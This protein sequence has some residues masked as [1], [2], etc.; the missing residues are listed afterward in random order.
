ML[1]LFENLSWKTKVFTKFSK[2]GNP[3]EYRNQATGG[4]AVEGPYLLGLFEN[5]AW[6]R[7]FTKFLIAGEPARIS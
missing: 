1:D 7:I 5:I 6:N 3:E 4:T 2:L